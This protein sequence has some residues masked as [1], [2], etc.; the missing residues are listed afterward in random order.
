MWPVDM[1]ITAPLTATDFRVRVDGADYTPL[2]VFAFGTKT[3]RMTV[4]CPPPV[5][6]STVRQIRRSYGLYQASNGAVVAPHWHTRR[7]E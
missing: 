4:A 1:T 3:L 5:T 2:Y 6:V 7:V